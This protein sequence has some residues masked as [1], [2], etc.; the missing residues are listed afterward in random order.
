MKMRNHDWV[1]IIA[2]V[3]IAGCLVYLSRERS[4]SNVEIIKTVDSLGQVNKKLTTF[5]SIQTENLN[6]FLDSLKVLKNDLQR[7]KK[8][9]RH[10]NLLLIRK[11]NEIKRD[12]DR[13]TLP[14][15]PDF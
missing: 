4:G 2:L 5:D 14:D 8:E 9:R 12:F 1:V 13:I 11:T 10:E 15:R 7:E 6:R 3:I